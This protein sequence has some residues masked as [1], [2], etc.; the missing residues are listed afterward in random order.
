[1]LR[2]RVEAGN[3]VQAIAIQQRQRAVPVEDIAA[4]VADQQ[5]VDATSGRRAAAAGDGRDAADGEAR[6]PEAPADDGADRRLF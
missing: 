5:V 2:P 1:M 4:A 3:S 6:L